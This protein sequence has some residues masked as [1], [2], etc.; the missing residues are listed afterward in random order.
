MNQFYWENEWRLQNLKEESFRIRYVMNKTPKWINFVEKKVPETL[1]NTL[2]MAFTKAFITVFDKGEVII[3]KTYNKEKERRIFKRN[4]RRL[5]REDFNTKTFRKFERQARRTINWNLGISLIEGIGLGVAGCGIP[6]IPIFVSLLLKSIYE[7][8]ISY[9]FSY[10][11]NQEKLFILKLIDTALLSGKELR[12]KDEDVDQLIDELCEGINCK[13][14]ED[15]FL[16]ELK[17]TRQIDHSAHALSHE[18]L[19][20]KFLQGMTFIGIIGGIT[21]FICLKRITNYVMLKYKRRFLLYQM[22]KEL[23][24]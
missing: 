3:E 9:G 16:V 12:E 11:N 10:S 5:R 2:E 13:V 17:I 8:S 21:D 7:I 4:V 18:L 6:D 20:G 22:E 19:Y 14:Q 15:D 23:H 24:D 1:Q